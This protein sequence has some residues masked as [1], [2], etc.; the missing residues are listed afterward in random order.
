MALSVIQPCG[1]ACASAQ[2]DA[3]AH[4]VRG[5]VLDEVLVRDDDLRTPTGLP[6]S[7]AR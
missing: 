4:L 1:S 5:H 7:Y 2:L 6:F 3:L